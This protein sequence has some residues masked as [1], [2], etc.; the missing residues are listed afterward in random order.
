MKEVKN[1]IKLELTWPVGDGLPLR[2]KPLCG[3]QAEISGNVLTIYGPGGHVYQKMP[4][5]YT[6]YVARQEAAK[7]IQLMLQGSL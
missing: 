2:S 6:K 3:Y 4:V 7:I 5:S 1:T